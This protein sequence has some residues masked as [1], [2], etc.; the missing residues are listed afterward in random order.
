MTLSDV[1]II[2]RGKCDILEETQDCVYSSEL[3]NKG[4]FRL[5]RHK[6]SRCDKVHSQNFKSTTPFHLVV[7]KPFYSPAVSLLGTG[8]S[9]RNVVQNFPN[10]KL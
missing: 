1:V 7:H 9:Q 10:N 2:A 4:E 6:M 8:D 5:P 3:Q